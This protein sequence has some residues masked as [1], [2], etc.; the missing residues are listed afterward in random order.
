MLF[1]RKHTVV[2]HVMSLEIN[3]FGLNIDF[4]GIY[5]SVISFIIEISDYT[6]NYVIL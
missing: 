4:A 6:I 1:K 3:S 2:M 5:N